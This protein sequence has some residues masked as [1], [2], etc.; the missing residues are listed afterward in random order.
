MGQLAVSAQG[1]QMVPTGHPVAQ[2]TVASLGFLGT[3]GT[4]AWYNVGATVVTTVVTQVP[5][6][7]AT[8]TDGVEE[9]LEEVATGSKLIVRCVSYGA[10][11]IS[12]ISIVQLGIYILC[13]LMTK[14]RVRRSTSGADLHVE[15][16]G[17]RLAGG[18]KVGNRGG[19]S[20]SVAE[21]FPRQASGPS[22]GVAV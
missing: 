8:V 12:A 3:L 4:I 16:Y 20:V 19:L 9:V 21:L 14:L 2:V 6:I 17:A 5:E 15:K 10:L 1:M 22:R 11:I 18:G 13:W 7:V